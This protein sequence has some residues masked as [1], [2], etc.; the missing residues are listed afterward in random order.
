MADARRKSRWTLQVQ[1][2]SMCSE[3]SQ[4][5]PTHFSPYVGVVVGPEAE[6]LGA[7]L[8]HIYQMIAAPEGESTP[9]DG[10]MTWIDDDG[11]RRLRII[12]SR[13]DKNCPGGLQP[14]VAFDRKVRKAAKS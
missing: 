3:A 14:Y 11:N 7:S 13:R 9:F 4:R 2:S 1:T 10:V 12:R 5:P 8:R 6:T